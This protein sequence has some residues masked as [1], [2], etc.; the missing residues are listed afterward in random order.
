MAGM[1]YSL[2]EVAEKLNKKPE[3]VKQIIREGRLREFRD[4]PN[5]LFKVDEVEAL[6]SEMNALASKETLPEIEQETTEEE[7]S[8]IPETTEEPAAEIELTSADTAVSGEEINVLS[9]TDSEYQLI[10]DTMD[11]TKAESGEAVLE[12]G[13]IGET[14]AES[15]EAILEEDTMGETKA[16]SEEA[17]LAEDTLSE[18]KAE[19]GE[20]VL[21]EDTLAEVKAETDEEI[22]AEDTMDETKAASGEAVL[23]DDTLSETAATTDEASLEAIEEDVNLD[24]FG[25]GSGLLDLS[26]QADDTSLGGILDEIYAPEGE[27]GQETKETIEAGSAMDVT[28]TAEQ[29]LSETMQ[30]G[31]EAPATA[32]I[33][34][35]PEPDTLSNAFGIMLFLPLLAIVY[36]AVVAITGFSGV[37]PMILEKIQGMIWYIMIG[38][39][40]AA[41]LTVGVAFVLSGEGGKLGKKKVKA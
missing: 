4:G 2:Q 25:S 30:P 12:E 10:D 19:P 38:I 35:E 26:L 16:E 34:A 1:F 37:M 32:H 21:P 15:G 5:L 7:I 8:L 36:T 29:M 27:A 6:M 13:R 24:T 28:A 20:A 17:I 9:E 3:E 14:E 22:L 11:E 40:V 18:A 39:A 33:T 31:L 23:A 41:A